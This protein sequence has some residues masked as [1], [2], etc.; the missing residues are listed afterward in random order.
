MPKFPT[1]G[2]LWDQSDNAATE[3]PIDIGSQDFEAAFDALDD[4]AADDFVLTDPGP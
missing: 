3:P 4:Q 2:F 1:G